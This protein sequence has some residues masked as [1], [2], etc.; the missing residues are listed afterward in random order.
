MFPGGGGGGRSAALQILKARE[1]GLFSDVGG[2]R[3]YSCCPAAA[4]DRSQSCVPGEPLALWEEQWFSAEGDRNVAAW[5]RC[6]GQRRKSDKVRPARWLLLWKLGLGNRSV[7]VFPITSC[8]ASM[9]SCLL[10]QQPHGVLGRALPYLEAP[11]L[12]RGAQ[13]ERG[14]HRS[15]GAGDVSW[16]WQAWDLWPSPLRGHLCS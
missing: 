11:S 15:L 10:P 7:A 5:P 8:L 12:R 1:H 16:V 2:S 13:G 6:V 14:S 3:P 9:P 4:W